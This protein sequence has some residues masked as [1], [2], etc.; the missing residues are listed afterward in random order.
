VTGLARCGDDRA[1]DRAT[2]PDLLA[3]VSFARDPRALPHLRTAL[4]ISDRRHNLEHVH[5][6]RV[7]EA[8]S[9]ELS[10]QLVPEIAGLLDLPY[11]LVPAAKLLGDLGPQ[12][13]AHPD[14]LPQLSAAMRNLRHLGQRAALAVAHVRLTGGFDDFTLTVLQAAVSYPLQA[15]AALDAVG[16]LGPLAEPLLPQIEKASGPRQQPDV[17]LAAAS[18]RWR[19]TGD[20]GP[21]V[22]LFAACVQAN[23]PPHHGLRLRAV[24]ELAI[25]GSAP[26]HLHPLLQHIATSKRRVIDGGGPL[27]WAEKDERLRHAAGLLVDAAAH[28]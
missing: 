20:P 17:R 24:Q 2:A 5:A 14:V 27:P 3:L 18:V 8:L 28:G 6:C 4:R 12:V 9:P 19:I 7:L 11:P 16:L 25:I 21:E 23:Q 1:L 22:P 13:S 26:E 15:A 10:A